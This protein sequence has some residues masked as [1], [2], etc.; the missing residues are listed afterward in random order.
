MVAIPF[1]NKTKQTKFEGT[2]TLDS[3]EY[4]YTLYLSP[5]RKQFTKNEK[6][7]II[8]YF[9]NRYVYNRD[10][11]P[12]ERCLDVDTVT[13]TEYLRSRDISAFII[14]KPVGVD[15]TASGTLQIYDW[16]FGTNKIN[17]ANVW[18]NDVCRVS[19]SYDKTGYAVKALFFFMEQL[20]IQNL[21]KTNIKLYVDPAKQT[22]LVR[23]YESLGFVIHPTQ[24]TSTEIVME[25]QGLVAQ[26][27]IIDLSSLMNGRRKLTSISSPTSP[28][29]ISSPPT[30]SRNVRRK[31]NGGYKKRTNKT[32]KIKK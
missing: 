25:K 2:F 12:R 14:V 27:D 5:I 23:I 1:I 20:V 26:T 18:I 3:I 31:P 15:N 22:V 16:D 17:L 11:T 28:T 8:N 30:N 10:G 24:T 9:G 29:S 7:E 13:V 32:K 21:S 19:P 4:V 6:T